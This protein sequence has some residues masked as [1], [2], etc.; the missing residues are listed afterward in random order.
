MPSDDFVYIC[1]KF[2]HA[3]SK[4]HNCHKNKED[5]DPDVIA[6]LHAVLEKKYHEWP[7]DVMLHFVH[8]R[9]FIIIFYLN[10]EIKALDAKSKL[11]QLNSGASSSVECEL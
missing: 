10:N 3:F 9:T 8:T 6:H 7:S 4:F 1:N 5:Q 11:R 2:E